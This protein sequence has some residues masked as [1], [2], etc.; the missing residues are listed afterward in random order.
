MSRAQAPQTP[1]HHTGARGEFHVVRSA[2]G[3]VADTSSACRPP[4]YSALA[5]PRLAGAAQASPDLRE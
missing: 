1:A 5:A 2:A 4:M 3:V